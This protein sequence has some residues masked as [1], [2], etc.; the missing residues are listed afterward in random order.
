MARSDRLFKNAFNQA[1]DRVAL[2]ETIESISA[3]AQ[4]LNVSR[5]TARRILFELEDRSL[6]RR[7]GAGWRTQKVP[8]RTDYFP[9]KETQ[10]VEETL[11]AAFMEWL[12]KED[13]HPGTRISE[14]SIARRLGASN[15]S[16]REL[17]IRLSRF[18][19]LRKEP[20]RSWV[21]EGFTKEYAAEMHEVRQ[22][23]EIRAV[24]KLT[25]LPDDNQFWPRIVQMLKEHELF[26][27]G[28]EDHYVDFPKLDSSFHRLL[29]NSSH[30]R[31]IESFQDAITLIF[32]YH[33]R[34]NKTE[35]K[36]RNKI[37]ALEHIE[38]I[39]AILDRQPEKAKQALIRH[40]NT[41]E[42]TFLNSIEW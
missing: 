9:V 25:D 4:R 20:Q 41:A 39:E 23:F 6:V 1:L 34:W 17:L 24:E 32:H 13:V 22:L 35:E 21:L 37:A 36:Q 8:K 38:I 29:N 19:F 30:N 5:N 16:V 11:E 12:A 26:L 27:E 40:L 42:I 2:N 10:S 33:Y 18:G 31:F 14:A 7:E 28:Y 15:S 3:L